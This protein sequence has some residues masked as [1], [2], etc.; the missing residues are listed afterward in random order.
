M[1]ALV[2]GAAGFI[3][4]TLVDKLLSENYEVIGIDK[5]TPYY[6]ASIKRRNISNAV[7]NPK[8][9]LLE[10]DLATR[11]DE[12]LLDG[13]THIFHQAGQPGVRASWGAE[14]NEYVEWNIRATQ[15]LLELAS[16]SGGVTSFVAASS[17][18]VYGNA[19]KYPTNETDLPSP[20]S[21]YG[22]TKLAAEN[23]CT[24]YG[25]QFGLPTI[26]LRYFTVF[27]PRQRPDM[28]MRRM[29]DS[30]LTG[31]EFA[32]SGNGE[33]IRDFTYVD[34]VVEAI[35]LSSRYISKSIE[36]ER[37]IN[38]G[39][40]Q[41]TSLLEVIATIE[42][43]SNT[44]VNLKFEA[45]A[46]GDPFRTGSDSTKARTVLGWNPQTTVDDGMVKM[47]DWAKQL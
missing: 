4:S 19:K 40:G 2:T 38:I 29:M 11:L 39:G 33:Q 5:F 47:F 25:D 20:V 8:Y 42:K 31:C 14:F 30:V 1:K 36:P 44:K 16:K 23:L 45:N 35:I 26:S 18:S 15:N 7:L 34:D 32:I 28:A 10:I 37:V 41:Q 27:G 21:P 3:G 9:K 46:K 43:I 12:N 17:S 24:L 13:V 6:D 22:V